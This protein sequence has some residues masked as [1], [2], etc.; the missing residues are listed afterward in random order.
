M[1]TKQAYLKFLESKIDV[2]EW[3]GFE[4]DVSELHSECFPHQKDAIRWAARIGRGL[5]AMSFGLGKTRIAIELAKQVVNRTGGKFLMICP[6]GVKHQFIN[7]DGPVLGVN[8]QYVTSNQDIEM[9]NTPYL[10]TNYERVRDG[11]ITLTDKDGKNIHNIM[12]ANLDEGSVLRSLGSKTYEIFDQQFKSIPYRWVSTATPSPNRYRELIY[13]AGFFGIMDKGQALTRFFQRDTSKAGNLTLHPQH[14]EAFWL[15]VASWA[16]FVYKPSDLGYSDLGYELPPLNVYWHKIPVDHRRA[17]SQVDSWGQHRMF[18]DAAAGV[19]EAVNEKRAT[20]EVRINKAKEIIQDNPGH[21]LIWHHLEDE[22]KAISMSIPDTV[23]V[24]GSQPLEIR[25]QRILDFSHGKISKLST[26][27]EIAGSG[28]NF[29]KYCHK[30]IFLGIDYRFQDFIQAIHRTHR[31]QQANPVDVHIIFAESEEQIAMTL[32]RKWEQHDKLV[33]KMQDIVKK[34]GLTHWAIE[35][36]LKRNISDFRQEYQG[37]FFK[38][39]NTDSTLELFNLVEAMEQGA[40]DP[41][42]IKINDKGILSSR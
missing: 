16:L 31:F 9:A 3:Q 11:N 17:W 4:I 5:I 41:F 21:Y 39:V 10:I 2:V 29:Q 22:R 14:E 33:K 13:Y 26:K 18:L 40:T 7:E 8:F 32:K 19:K 23:A 34:Y 6:L 25:E 15:W 27:P 37:N 36:G 12:G 24:Y 30:N 20:I 28:C 38:L 35:T 42:K 1:T